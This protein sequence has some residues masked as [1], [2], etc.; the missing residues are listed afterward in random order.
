MS[1]II[2]IVNALLQYLLVTAFLLRVLLP[3]ARANMRNPLCQAVLRVTSPLVMPLRKVFPPVG[4]VDTASV[5]ALILVQLVTTVIINLLSGFIG[6]PL[7][8]ALR[9]V[10]MIL[11]STLQVYTIAV[12]IYVLLSYVA[13]GAHSPGRELLE[14][15]CEPILRPVRRLI[16]PIAQ[17]DFTPVFVLIG[18]QALQR[19]ALPGLYAELLRMLA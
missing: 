10:F 17:I 13:P 1:A 16:P 4:R 9:V 11:D 19:F 8:I 6:T 7:G 18:L 15:L 5:V 14:S 2:F 3:L 12:F